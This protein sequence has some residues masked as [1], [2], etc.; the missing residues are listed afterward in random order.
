MTVDSKARQTPA[1]TL[2][3]L[4]PLGLLRWAWRQLTSMR[5][6]LFLLMLLAVAAVPG[7]VLPQRSIDPAR[8]QQYLQ[9]HPTAGPVVDTL[10][11]FDVYASV[12]FSAIYLLLFV[13]LVGC[14]LPRTRAHLSALRARPPRTPRRLERLPVHRTSTLDAAPGQVLEAARVALRSRRYRV[15]RHEG[16]RPDEGSLAAERG[17]LRETGNLLF[18]LSLVGLLVAVAAGG[19]YGYRGQAI[20]PVGQA[21]ANSLADYDTFDP[22]TWFDPDELP[23][24]SLSVDDVHVAFE[25]EAGGNQFGA[26]RDFDA[27]VTVRP[28]PEADPRRETLRVNQ[29]LDVRGAHVYLAGN[30]YAPVVTVRDGNGDVAFAGPVPFLAQD[31]NYTSTGV[32][33][34]PDARPGQIGLQGL[35]LPTAVVTPETGP[36]SVFP[37]AREPRL[38]FTAYVGDLGLDEGVPQSAYQ[39]DAERMTQLTTP[40]GGVFS[41]ALAPGESVALPDGHGSVSFDRLDRFA[42]LT[43]RHDPGKVPALVFAVLA[44][45]GLVASLFVPRRRM[46]VRA[47][48]ESPG[49]TVVEVAGLA[50]GEDAGLAAE[51]ESVEK[52]LREAL[53]RPENAEPPVVAAAEQEG[54][55]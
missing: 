33:K 39:L 46:W 48:E 54:G 41:A 55:A 22:G 34:A 28:D 42:G 38:F 50:R 52:A 20:V 6:A 18:H 16:G 45:L 17:H 43:I 12:W 4:G 47:V 29:P 27:D 11:G 14:V 1:A 3:E 13:S 8:V 24:F 9:D 15:E 26:P 23:P 5:T 36:I 10:G 49:R 2:P 32:V 21:W 37:D 25:E 53:G 35:F 44:M 40:D 51:A 19:L 30:G 7:S 31:G